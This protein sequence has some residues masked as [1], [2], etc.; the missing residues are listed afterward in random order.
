VHHEKNEKERESH[1]VEWNVRVDGRSYKA[2]SIS[3]YI[4][5]ND[6]NE[7]IYVNVNM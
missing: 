6:K 3:S 7:W 2:N 4:I 5:M 1:L